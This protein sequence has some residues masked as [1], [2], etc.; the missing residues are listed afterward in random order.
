[1]SA[2]RMSKALSSM[3][4]MGGDMGHFIS[5]QASENIMAWRLYR[6]EWFG[7]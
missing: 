7:M 6:E 4:A 3:A 1:M 5:R 2:R